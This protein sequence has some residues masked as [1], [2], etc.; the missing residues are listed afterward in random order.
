MKILRDVTTNGFLGYNNIQQKFVLSTNVTDTNDNYVVEVV[1]E[2]NDE[3]ILKVNIIGQFVIYGQ[4]ILPNYPL[5]TSITEYKFKVEKKKNNTFIIH[6]TNNLFSI[7]Y[8]DGIN[9]YKMGN[10]PRISYFQTFEPGK[11][12]NIWLLT[13]NNVYEASK[14]ACYTKCGSSENR[15]DCKNSNKFATAFC[16]AGRY[17]IDCDLGEM[18]LRGVSGDDFSL[19]S[20]GPDSDCTP[21]ARKVNK[22]DLCPQIG[23]VKAV[24]GTYN[25]PSNEIYKLD[26]I[27]R[28][29]GGLNTPLLCEYNY[30]SIMGATDGVN[31]DKINENAGIFGIAKQTSPANPNYR[32]PTEVINRID[33]DWCGMVVGPYYNDSDSYYN[34]NTTI[35]LSKD[36]R[37]CKP[38]CLNNPN[39]CNPLL[40]NY[41]RGDNLR[42]PTCQT[43]CKTNDCDNELQEFCK[44]KNIDDPLYSEICPCFLPTSFYNNYFED[45]RTK[46]P[47][48]PQIYSIKECSFPKCAASSIKPYTYSNKEQCPNI[49]QCIQNA[50]ISN[51][52]HINNIDINFTSENCSKFLNDCGPNQIFKDGG[53]I[54]CAD[55]KVPNSSKSECVEFTC[56][57]DKY[58]DANGVCQSCTGGR[59]VNSTKTGCTCKDN[60][61]I[62][63]N[64]ECENCPTGKV[65][66]S[67]KTV[68]VDSTSKYSC[69]FITK[70]CEESIDGKY[71][72][73]DECEKAC[74]KRFLLFVAGIIIFLFL[75]IAIG[76]FIIK[77]NNK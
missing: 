75:I 64:N 40:A 43:Y 45:L 5:S 66:N 72:T 57:S 55:N 6:D 58:I 29:G 35:R 41:C 56:P 26:P 48:F 65:P 1:S 23:F 36:P 70:K 20:N 15:W 76:I 61:I 74:S 14:E 25:T 9:I 10:N 31:I 51:T 62:N 38:W 21:C 63:A 69:N 60:Q 59:V 30:D 37:F 11:E 17:N 19:C 44:D 8:D 18:R 32:T 28:S 12:P 53:C 71:A 42:D 33:K 16:K 47:K 39:E 24:S 2:Q 34:K 27:P 4:E 68:C 67:N 50:D 73:L 77:K 3:L 54:T 22:P 46:Y 7:Y 52:G 13:A 49:V